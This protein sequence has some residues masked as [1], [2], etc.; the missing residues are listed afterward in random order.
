M[1]PFVLFA[2]AMPEMIVS[3]TSSA[4]FISVNNQ[5]ATDDAVLKCA[6][7]SARNGYN[8]YFTSDADGNCRYTQE[9]GSQYKRIDV[10]KHISLFIPWI[11]DPKYIFR[12]MKF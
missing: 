3:Q 9:T 8:C 11:K 2:L 7:L 4:T 12:K 1:L 6:R 5:S 10:S